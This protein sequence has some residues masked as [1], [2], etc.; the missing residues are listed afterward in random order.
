[1]AGVAEASTLTV[2]VV[3]VG[4]VHARKEQ[5]QEIVL[6]VT[7]IVAVDP[8]FELH[9]ENFVVTVKVSVT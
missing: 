4:A 6:I 5:S 7:A 9:K 1:M 3:A 8:A 2:A